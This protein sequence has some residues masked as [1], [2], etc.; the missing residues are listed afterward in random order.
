MIVELHILQNFAP[1]N[2]NRDD[3][4]S[5]KDCYF[6]GHRRARI[7]SQCFKRATRDEFKS[8]ELLDAALLSKRTKRLVE[9][10]AKRLASRGAPEESAR[11][12]AT[13]LLNEIGLKVVKDG[14]TEYLLFLAESE[15]N[16]AVELAAQQWSALNTAAEQAR[17]QAQAGTGGGGR[18]KVD[19]LPKEIKTEM[20][21]RLD[22]GRAADLALFGRMIANLPDKNV[23]AACQVAHAI[24]T[25][26]V[27][28]EFDFYTAVDDL[29]PDDTAGADMLGTVEFNSACFYRYANVDTTQLLTNLGGDEGL[30]RGT[31][32][33]FLQASVAAIPTGKQNSMA[34]HNPPSLVMITARKRSQWNL[35]NAFIR[36]IRPYGETDLIQASIA[37]LDTYW[38]R[39]TDMYGS[40]YESAWVATT[41]PDKLARLATFKQQSVEQAIAAA[42]GS[43]TFRDTRGDR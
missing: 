4:G 21:R 40:A 8:A 19:P 35:A 3:T 27:D 26:K 11:A 14:K 43:V 22:G 5:P 33:A 15:I 7:S 25:N 30:A 23:E 2:L 28:V 24:S 20:L 37:A 29:K 38:G 34:A 9:E 17:A 42:L 13:A 18:G 6:G 41:E 10:I 12:V 31:L 16:A 32:D 36:P 1:A 39:L